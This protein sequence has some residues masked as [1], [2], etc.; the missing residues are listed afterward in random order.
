MRTG[1]I[2]RKE[3]MTR[4]FTE[5]GVQVPVT[6]LRIDN[7][8]VV[9]QRTADKDGYVALQLGAGTAKIKR[10]SKAIQCRNSRRSLTVSNSG[11]VR[12]GNCPHQGR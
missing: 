10:T 1:V 9:G 2:A 6:V 11:N 4:I 12:R 5:D 8:Q 3:G 7:C